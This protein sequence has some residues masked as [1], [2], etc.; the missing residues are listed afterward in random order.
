MCYHQ[1]RKGR[2]SARLETCMP[3]TMTA[4]VKRHPGPGAEIVTVPIPSTGPTDVL[5][6]VQATSIC[7]TDLHIYQW[8]PWAAHR[9][10]P[11]RIPGHEFCGEVVRVGERVT[12][13]KPGD[14]VSGESHVPCGRCHPCRTGHRHICA[15]LKI[16]GVELDGSFAE[17]VCLPEGNAWKTSPDLA[18]EVAC[19][20]EPFGNAVQTALAAQLTAANVLVTGCGPIG[21]FAV[22]IARAAG[23]ATVIA[24]DVNEYRLRLA[25]HNGATHTLNDTQE[26]VPARVRE[27]TA[28][29]GVDVVLEMSGS[30][31][32]IAQGFEVLRPGGHVSLLGLPPGPVQLDL[33]DAII[34]KS[35]TVKGITGRR[36]WETW[37]QTAAFLEGGVI[38]V[39]PVI[40]HRLPLS[41]FHH[42]M[43]LLESGQSGKIVLFPGE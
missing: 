29:V 23:A 21:I 41:E 40:T 9:I 34:F 19:L 22:A 3:Q 5:L 7:G 32:A 33:N 25:G 35:A 18:P 12:S 17:Y 13:L 10:Q 26:D 20:Q 4:V 43:E 14:Y 36:I 15:N 30:P 6:K 27:M 31:R 39:R 37:Y 28:G 24:T 8:N 38:D 2:P 16:I 42:A 11:P 1:H